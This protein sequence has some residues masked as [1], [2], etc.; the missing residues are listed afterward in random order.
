MHAGKRGERNGKLR[1]RSVVGKSSPVKEDL[2]HR[3]QS[4]PS[5]LECTPALLDRARPRGLSSFRAAGKFLATADRNNFLLFPG[6]LIG[7]AWRIL[8][9]Q[10]LD[11]NWKTTPRLYIER[12]LAVLMFPW[13]DFKRK[14]DDTRWMNT[15]SLNYQLYM[16]NYLFPRIPL[17]S[18]FFQILLLRIAIFNKCFPF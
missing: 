8:L 11:E 18:I 6:A 10:I 4:L 1:I 14:I 9:C 5:S 13:R 12:S 7:S 16:V 2:R 17:W 3:L 15:A